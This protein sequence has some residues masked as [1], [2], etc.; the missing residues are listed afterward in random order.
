MTDF[1]ALCI[2]N[3]VRILVIGPGALGIV[4][5]AKLQNA[6]HDVVLAVRSEEK[7]N[8]L[9]GTITLREEEDQSVAM[10]MV[11]RPGQVEPVDGIIHTTKLQGAET[12]ASFWLPCLKPDG[13]FM[14]YQNGVEGDAMHDVVGE[15][16]VEASV[17]WTS[18]LVQPGV[19]HL[20][21]PGV[22]AI[23]RWPDELPPEGLA[24]ALSCIQP[25]L[26]RDDMLDV[27][28]SKMILNSSITTPGIIIGETMGAIAENKRARRLI[29]D[30]LLEG[31][32]VMEAAGHK[33]VNVGVT[34]VRTLSS[35][36]RFL[37]LLAIKSLGRKYRNYKSSGAQGLARGE[38]TEIDF[39]NG[40]ISR[41]GARLGVPTPVNDWMVEV[42][43]KIE[44]G[45]SQGFH[46]LED[47]PWYSC[48]D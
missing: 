26:A 11:W 39:M 43:K 34:R 12:I 38:P 13:W 27:K 45:E 1:Q 30:C 14:P 23:G 8:Q 6:G 42:V 33:A 37:A 10:P 44:A 46:W 32:A 41:E 15:R 48:Q 3:A 24:E 40:R 20:T 9:D 28:W 5:A 2:C 17:Y 19:S 18:T 4:A 31:R 21:G 29:L 25:T 35:L 36:P 47:A 16:L 22:T 7:A